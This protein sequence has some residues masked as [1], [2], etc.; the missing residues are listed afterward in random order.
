MQ[1]VDQ[2]VL[3]E[4]LVDYLAA[5]H[6]MERGVERMLGS[7]LDSAETLPLRPAFERHQ[8]ETREHARLLEERLEELGPGPSTGKQVE[9]MVAALLKGAVDLVRTDRPGKSGRDAYVAEHAEIA[10]YELL[11]RL[12]RR[13]G[14]EQT[15]RLA[16]RICAEERAM[17]RTLDES[18][19]AFLDATLAEWTRGDDSL[20]AL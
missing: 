17:A 7:L 16:E 8:A 20:A 15:A 12:A 18:W 13:A 5:A 4:K 11:G 3:R 1:I 10:A 9:G 6:A 19:D 2:D 14:D